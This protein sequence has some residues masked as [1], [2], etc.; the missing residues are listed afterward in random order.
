MA[1]DKIRICKDIEAVRIPTFVEKENCKVFLQW[2]GQFIKPSYVELPYKSQFL[3]EIKTILADAIIWK[4]K[5]AEVK[6]VFV[7]QFKNIPQPPTEI[8]E[9]K[10]NNL[11][12]DDW[13]VVV[14][15]ENHS[16]KSEAVFCVIVPVELLVESETNKI[17]PIPY[18]SKI[19]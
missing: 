12:D 3:F 16:T 10:S 9:F 6:V 4:N 2:F 8:I 18:I 5:I 17:S 13:V 15:D 19:Y 14:Y 7:G 1:M 11:N